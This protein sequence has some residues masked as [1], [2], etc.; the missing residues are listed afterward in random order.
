[1]CPKICYCSFLEKFLGTKQPVIWRSQGGSAGGCRVRRGRGYWGYARS[2]MT[3]FIEAQNK[4]RT[5]NI[6]GG[7]MHTD[8]HVCVPHSAWSTKGCSPLTSLYVAVRLHASMHAL[9]HLAIVRRRRCNSHHS[10]LRFLTYYV[11][12]LKFIYSMS[13]K[14]T[15]INV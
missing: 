10:S 1:M 6:C 12:C 7:L 4:A 5:T 2:N 15:L 13:L 14:Y 11:S 3:M 9:I 8:V